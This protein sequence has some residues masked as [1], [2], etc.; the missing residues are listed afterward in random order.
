MGPRAAPEVLE[1]APARD[2]DHVQVARGRDD[3]PHGPQPAAHGQGAP[4]GAPLPDGP[5]GPVL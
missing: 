1:L 4:P 2:D 3:A 5:T